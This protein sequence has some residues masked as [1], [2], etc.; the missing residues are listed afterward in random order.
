MRELIKELVVKVLL[1]LLDKAY[2]SKIDPY[3]FPQVLNARFFLFGVH[4]VKFLP[5]LL[6]ISR[7]F[8]SLNQKLALLVHFLILKVLLLL[9][10]LLFKSSLMIELHE[11]CLQ[12]IVCALYNHRLH[13]HLILLI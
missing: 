6:L 8:L 5:L 13:P 10:A 3:F 1:R 9:L 11:L 12:A 4:F 2:L 7:P